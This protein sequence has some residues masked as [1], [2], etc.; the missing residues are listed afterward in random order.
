LT[1]AIL[2]NMRER[3]VETVAGS[4][5][6]P[7]QLQILSRM[8]AE[9]EQRERDQR[10]YIPAAEVTQIA[11]DVFSEISEF[12]AGL[13]NM[14]DP[15]GL[16][17]PALRVLIDDNART[18]LLGFHKRLKVL[19]DADAHTSTPG[20]AVSGARKSRPRRQRA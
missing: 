16:L 13:S 4:G 9:I 17:D 12:V 1:D 6:E 5:M 10:L 2:G 19:L 20:G 7:R 18:A 8:S 14:I 11:G 3:R 15:N